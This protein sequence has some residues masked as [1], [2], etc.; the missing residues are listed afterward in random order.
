MLEIAS[1]FVLIVFT[2]LVFSAINFVISSTW[3]FIKCKTTIV[4]AEYV[5]KVQARSD[6]EE[7]KKD[8][9]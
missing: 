6:K 1:W 8:E 7:D 3:L 9:K 4:N 5:G 2:Y